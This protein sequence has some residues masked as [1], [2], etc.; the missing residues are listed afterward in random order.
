MSSAAIAA[1]RENDTPLIKGRQPRKF[2]PENIARIKDWVAQ[3]VGRDEIANRLEVT[4]G[5][6]Q[7]TCSKLGISLRKSSSANGKGAI[8]PLP[9]VQS[10]MEHIPQSNTPAS[11]KLTL[12]ISTRNR[13]AAFDLPLRQDL[14]AQLTLEAAVRDLTIFSLIGK[15]VSQAIGKDLVSEIVRKRPDPRVMTGVEG[16]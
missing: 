8:Q 6:L 14:L 11:V 1:V 5:S 3:G 9:V 13:Q 15:I 4:L 16:P 7:V 12:L 2:T 10:C